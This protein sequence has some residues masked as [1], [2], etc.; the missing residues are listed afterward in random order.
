MTD[1]NDYLRT[2]DGNFRLWADVM[3]LMLK[4]AAYAA[5]VCTAA[6]VSIWALYLIGLL[7]PE[8]ARQAED[9]TPFSA[10]V[11]IEETQT[12]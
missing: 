3:T 4:G 2:S 10:I 7:L 1:N 9:P 12:S 11:T 8:E 6:A 5:A